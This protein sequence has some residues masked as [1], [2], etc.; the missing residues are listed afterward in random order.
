MRNNGEIVEELIKHDS[1]VECVNEAG[2]TALQLA[3]ESGSIQ[4][5]KALV[6]AKVDVNKIDMLA[7]QTALHIAVAGCHREITEYLL[8]NVRLLFF[9]NIELFDIY[10]KLLLQ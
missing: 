8:K 5:V 9:N 1:D 6:K 7:G 2:R 4:A 3:V 10:L